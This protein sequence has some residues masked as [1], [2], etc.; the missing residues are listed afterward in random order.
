LITRKPKIGVLGESLGGSIVLNSYI[1]SLRAVVFWYPAFDL[2]DT[3]IKD[4]FVEEIK[5]TK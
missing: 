2:F 5:K 3:S 4:C 1:K